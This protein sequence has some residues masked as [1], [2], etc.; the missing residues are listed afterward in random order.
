[1][2]ILYPFFYALIFGL[3]RR[4]LGWKDSRFRRSI[5][6]IDLFLMLTP[7]LKFGVTAYVVISGL[8]A[9]MWTMGHNFD[10]WT[11]VLRYPVI[12]AWYPIC[13]KF[14]RPEWNR[15]TFIDG[16]SAVAEILVGAS[17]GAIIGGAL[18]L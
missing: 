12:G 8:S 13:K 11:V 5:L 1:M 9:I 10:R 16:Y 7:L 14:W 4:E 6:V 15:G 3:W 2:T 18:C 17:Y